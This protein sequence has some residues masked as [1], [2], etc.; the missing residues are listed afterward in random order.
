M[1]S[2]LEEHGVRFMLSNSVAEFQ[3]NLAIMQNGTTVDF[4][5]LVLAVGVKA[6]TTL[7]KDSGCNTD[8]GIVIDEHCMTTISDIY[9]AGDCSEGNDITF[10]S[11]RVLAILPNA[12]LQGECAGKNMAGKEFSFFNAI[13]M[14]SIGFF[15]LHAMSAGS[16]IDEENGGI[17]YDESDKNS[18]RR[19]YVK[20]GKLNGYMLVG[21][22]TRGGIFTSL[23]REQ[24]PLS[25]I[26]FD[27]LRNYRS[28]A[29]FDASV[30]K[31][32]LGTK[33]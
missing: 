4:D 15:G 19:F 3:E 16:Y 26:D 6:N 32:K 29:A 28:L 27:L 17:I 5:V 1:Q 2:I 33:V 23:I 31:K 14:N 13:P 30:R 20:N 9:A 11:K 18:I 7:A 10:G 25:S 12:F 24:V 8:R 21:D 22:V